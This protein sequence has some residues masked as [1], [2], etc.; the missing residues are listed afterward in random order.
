[1][2]SGLGGVGGDDSNTI[3]TVGYTIH[4]HP[5]SKRGDQIEDHKLGGAP[6]ATRIHFSARK[7]CLFSS[8]ADIRVCERREGRTRVDPNTSEYGPLSFVRLIA[9]CL[10]CQ[11]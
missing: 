7:S 3:K 2:V 6:N 11:R 5:G 9:N 1:M 4:T 8:I 10:Q